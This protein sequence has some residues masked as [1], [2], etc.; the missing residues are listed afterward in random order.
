MQSIQSEQSKLL[1]EQ[2]DKYM[3]ASENEL[4]DIRQQIKQ[5]I[6]ISDAIL[7]ISDEASIIFDKLIAKYDIEEITMCLTNIFCKKF[8]AEFLNIY[9]NKTLYQIKYHHKALILFL[10]IIK[11][12]FDEQCEQLKYYINSD[13]DNS[14]DEEHIVKNDDLT[15]EFTINFIKPLINNIKMI[16]D[17]FNDNF[18]QLQSKSSGHEEEIKELDEIKHDI[19]EL[20]C[21][22]DLEE[23]YDDY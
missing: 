15:N 8:S 1:Y 12:V 22:F 16:Y 19:M 6:F 23:L 3:N 5:S 10:L 4:S 11:T 13:A 14:S 7:K 20:L 18:K 17:N 2:L 21:N 9:A